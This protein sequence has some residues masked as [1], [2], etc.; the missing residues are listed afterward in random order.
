LLVCVHICMSVCQCVRVRGRCAIVPLQTRCTPSKHTCARKKLWH[1]V[2][3][4]PD[5]P[6][7]RKGTPLH[8]AQQCSKRA[9]E[10]ARGIEHTAGGGGAGRDTRTRMCTQKVQHRPFSGREGARL[11]GC[12]ARA[13]AIERA[14]R[15]LGF[16]ATSTPRRPTPLH[17]DRSSPWCKPCRPMR[18]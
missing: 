17:H 15:F 6:L 3:A 1:V 4:P 16:R 9:K 12:Q 14:K 5:P 13:P 11:A 8:D 2:I 7:M 10:N 18:S